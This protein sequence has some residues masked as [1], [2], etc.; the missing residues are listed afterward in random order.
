MRFGRGPGAETKS[1]STDYLIGAPRYML[2]EGDGS[3]LFW[4]SSPHLP[5]EIYPR[6]L[7]TTLFKTSIQQPSGTFFKLFDVGIRYISR[8]AFQISAGLLYFKVRN[9]FSHSRKGSR[10]PPALQGSF[11]SS[12][13][14]I[15]RPAEVP[16]LNNQI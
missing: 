1:C 10:A 2:L 12:Y 6:R 4:D 16:R 13:Q 5:H 3:L 14:I 7:H 11:V 15:L 9:N 8:M